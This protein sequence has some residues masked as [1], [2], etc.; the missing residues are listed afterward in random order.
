MLAINGIN[1]CNNFQGKFT[2]T[3]IFF[4]Q[5]YILRR[6][7]SCEIGVLLYPIL[8]L[9]SRFPHCKYITLISLKTIEVHVIIL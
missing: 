2:L 5:I 8:Y 6:I 1:V 9:A 7:E 3:N 4:S